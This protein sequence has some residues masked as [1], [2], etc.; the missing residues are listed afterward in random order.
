MFFQSYIENVFHITP[1]K[2]KIKI[3]GE[4]WEGRK[5]IIKR[6]FSIG[7]VYDI[8]VCLVVGRYIVFC[9]MVLKYLSI[10]WY[11][12]MKSK[13]VKSF[14]LFM[15]QTHCTRYTFL[16]ICCAIW[17]EHFYWLYW[18]ASFITMDILDKRCL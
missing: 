7:E 9:C 12:W 2:R 17:I 10:L 5:Y 16:S 1:E 3:H 6:L 8:F 11:L 4:N 13:C 18:N 15:Q 14:A